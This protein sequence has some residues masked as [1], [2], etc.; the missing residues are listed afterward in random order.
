MFK[1]IIVKEMYIEKVHNFYCL[2]DITWM[3]KIKENER[4]SSRI[5]H[6]G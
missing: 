4:K 3:T 1:R 6:S 5:T 2:L